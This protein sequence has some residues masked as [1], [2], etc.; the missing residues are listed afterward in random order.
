MKDDPLSEEDLGQ[1]EQKARY[2]E[3]HDAIAA[4]E[5]PVCACIRDL[6]AELLPD[7]E[8]RPASSKGALHRFTCPGCGRI[9]LTNAM[10]DLCLDCQEQGVPPPER[11]KL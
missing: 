3:V 5:F 2:A 11:N 10:N 4:I 6:L 7:L 8:P 9:Y 1:D